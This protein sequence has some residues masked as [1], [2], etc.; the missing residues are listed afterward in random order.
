[1][2]A[3]PKLRYTPEGYL[4]I[5]RAAQFKSEYFHGEIF[6]MA[7]A[8]EDHKKRANLKAKSRCLPSSALYHWVRF[9]TA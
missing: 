4:E 2:S 8:S 3:A 9:M 6:A 1:M 7:G 5:D